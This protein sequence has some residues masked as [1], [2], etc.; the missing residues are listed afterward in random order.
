MVKFPWEP[1]IL[2]MTGAA[3]FFE[4]P[5]VNILM[6]INALFCLCLIS[7]VLMALFTLCAFML[8]NEREIR[9]PVMIEGRLFPIRCVV[10]FYTIIPQLF[11]MGIVLLVTIIAAVREGL[12]FSI[13]MTF[14][15]GGF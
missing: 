11:F 6:A 8:S 1:V 2:C 9:L 5:F 13:Q 4:F 15:T 10:A 12:V 3:L 7:L 14:L